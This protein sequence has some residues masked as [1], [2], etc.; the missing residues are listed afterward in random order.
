MRTL[1]A[2]AGGDKRSI[3]WRLEGLE[4]R[5]GCPHIS[6]EIYWPAGR[7]WTAEEIIEHVEACTSIAL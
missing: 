3:N 7:S 2:A 6:D 5:T 1:L 4:R